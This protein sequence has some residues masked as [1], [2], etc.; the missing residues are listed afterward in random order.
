MTP[1]HWRGPDR[2]FVIVQGGASSSTGSFDLVQLM[3]SEWTT[4]GEGDLALEVG[5][6]LVA[7]EISMI[8]TGDNPSSSTL[9]DVLILCL[10]AVGSWGFVLAMPVK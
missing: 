5:N 2:P 6:T 4:S 9:A 7:D 3:D 10:D 1:N 8:P